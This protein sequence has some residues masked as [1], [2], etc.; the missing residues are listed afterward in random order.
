[1]SAIRVDNS[2]NAKYVDFLGQQLRLAI[3][4]EDTARR[5][6]AQ[7]STL[8]AG[9]QVSPV[10]YAGVDEII[11]VLDG[12]LEVTLGTQSHALGRGD[13]IYAPIGQ[14]IR[15]ENR[16]AQ[17]VSMLTILVGGGVES[18]L[19][20]A[21]GKSKDAVAP[22]LQ[23]VGVELLVQD[24]AEYRHAIVDRGHRSFVGRADQGP[25]FWMAGDTYQILLA[26]EQTRGKIA[27]IHFDVPPGGGPV[28][29]IHTR[30]FEAFFILEGEVTLYAGGPIVVGRRTD[31]AVLPENIPHC[32]KN[33]SE[34]AAR[35]LAVVAPAG[36][37]RLI[38]TVGR[39]AIPGQNPP[40]LDGLEKQRLFEA[41][42]DFGLELRPDIEF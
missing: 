15:I 34:S 38:E 8:P 41:A 18:A 27:V 23:G 32:F 39:P 17:E 35:M 33:R 25:R 10:V 36:F 11:Y 26:G 30:D 22:I 37:D 7:L 40:P 4:E 14:P 13:L 29:H 6:S 1:M 12:E 2:E 9:F 21:D 28:P 16:S 42:P 20:E 31:V 19:I 24:D 5:L 3:R